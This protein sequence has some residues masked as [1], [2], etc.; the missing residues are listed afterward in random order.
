MGNIE[1]IEP[2]MHHDTEGGLLNTNTEFRENRKRLNTANRKE[3]KIYIA[4]KLR[5]TNTNAKNRMR[6]SDIKNI[7]ICNT[8]L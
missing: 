6:F 7:L 2:Q 5:N 4:K 1:Y 3:L 8:I